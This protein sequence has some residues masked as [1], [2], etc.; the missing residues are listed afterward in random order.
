MSQR[1][2]R[3][4]AAY[5][6]A[7][8][9]LRRRDA[10]R[11]NGED[12]TPGEIKSSATKPPISEEAKQEAMVMLGLDDLT[13]FEFETP[14]ELFHF[15]YPNLNPN[16]WQ[17]EDL[18]LLGKPGATAARP[19]YYNLVAANGSG[20]DTYIIVPT[21][22]YFILTKVRARCIVTTKTKEQLKFQTFKFIVDAAQEFERKLGH[23]VFDITEFHIEC[24]LTRSE[25]KGF[26]TNEPG[27]GEGYHPFPD[28]PTAEMMIIINEAKSIEEDMWTAFLRFTGFTH[29]L[30]ISSPGPQA[31]HFYKVSTADTT[32]RAPGNHILGIRYVRFVTAFECKHLER[33]AIARTINEY[34]ENSPHVRSSIFAEF[35]A[36][37]ANTIITVDSITAIREAIQNSRIERNGEDIGIGLDIAAGGDET[38]LTVRRGNVV[39]DRRY[40]IQSDTLIAM[41]MINTYLLSFKNSDYIF[42]ADNGGIG[43]SSLDYLI[44]AGWRVNRR[45][46]QSPAGNKLVFLNLGAEIWYHTKRLIERQFILLPD[47]D[48]KLIQQLTTRQLKS[49]ETSQGKI[50]LQSKPEAKAQGL[51]SPD[52]ADSFC[53]C[54]FSYRPEFYETPVA[55][56]KPILS[57]EDWLLAQKQQRYNPRAGDVE[58]LVEQSILTGPMFQN[59]SHRFN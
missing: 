14:L 32:I 10:A 46:N 31:G 11:L 43:Q 59:D 48:P 20:K 21:A 8:E 17:D 54:F 36:L 1:N 18:S 23:K 26:V 41:H 39:I 24:L 56:P 28:S 7:A 55:A 50:A 19:L 58:S 33:E 27:R 6:K 13:P 42:N 3:L 25:I 35:T 52:R 45:N 34:G 57:F 44:N 16:P 38:A 22:L 53:L 4:D 40:F 5:A 30:E 12:P 9:E 29:W 37:G 2:A 15:I 49:G 51:P 47:D